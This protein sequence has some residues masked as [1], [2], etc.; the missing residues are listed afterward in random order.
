MKPTSISTIW[1]SAALASVAVIISYAITA[2]LAG[3]AA[4]R[5]V[6]HIGS[7]LVLVGLVAM[8]LLVTAARR[9]AVVH[10]LFGAL[11]LTVGI[12]SL[13]LAL[14]APMFL[15]Y[16]AASSVGTGMFALTFIVAPYQL[17][18]AHQHFNLMWEANQDFAFS[19]YQSARAPALNTELFLV[20]L[21][22]EAKLYLP[23]PFAALD[24]VL[25]AVLVVT[26]L[27]GFN[28]RKVFPHFSCVAL[29][30]P[31]LTCF[32]VLLQVVL[33]RVLLALKLRELQRITGFVWEAD[34]EV[35][36]TKRKKETRRSAV[37]RR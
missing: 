1:L 35:R 2:K 13:F 23:F 22:V 27:A 15:L 33:F 12:E 20:D 10:A 14:S 19:R 34:T 28:L 3:G 8:F 26:A 11:L 9:T 21:H 18:R 32:V 5:Q 25:W 17:F 4:G 16:G 7:G 24:G 36:A 6:L 31:S 37:V 29:G 30:I